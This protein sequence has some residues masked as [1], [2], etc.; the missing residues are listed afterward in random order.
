[1]IT[2]EQ[3]QEIISKYGKNDQDSGSAPV[4]IALLTARILDLDKHFQRNRTASGNVKD[5]HSYRG[6]EKIINQRKSLQKY[7][8][9]K[10]PEGYQDLIKSLGLRK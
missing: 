7:Y 9:R 10:N 3:R 4:Q 1:M 5:K 2:K 6:L 8:K